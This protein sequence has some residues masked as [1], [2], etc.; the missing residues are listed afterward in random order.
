MKKKSDNCIV[1]CIIKR[2]EP[3]WAVINISECGPGTDFEQSAELVK[4][5]LV[6][7]GFD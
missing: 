6:H 1:V 3:F 7:A 4:S 5:S 2:E